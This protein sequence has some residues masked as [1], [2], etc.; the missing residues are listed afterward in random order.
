M[1]KRKEGKHGEARAVLR[2]SVWEN[3]CVFAFL[4]GT[5]FS[6]LCLNQLMLSCVA[7]VALFI[8]LWHLMVLVHCLISLT[9]G[10]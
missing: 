10:I 1:D 3:G 8:V 4:L 9:E 5:L 6:P 2:R 7:A